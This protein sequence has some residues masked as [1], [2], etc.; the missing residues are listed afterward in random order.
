MKKQ[1]IG[2]AV[3]AGLGALFMLGCGSAS[4]V[5]PPARSNATGSLVVFGSDAPLCDVL[6]FQVTIIGATLTSQGGGDPVSILSSGQSIPVD[7]ARLIDFTALLSF[8]SVPAGTYSQLTLTLSSPQ[9][10]VLDVQQVPPA[11]VAI[12]ATL[13]TSTATADIDPP[14]TVPSNGTA[15][16]AIDFRLRKSVQT[17]ANGQ[18]TGTVA[19]VLRAAPSIESPENGIGEVD[20]LHGIVR[21][22]STTSS[23]PSFTG[24]FTLQTRGGIGAVFTIYATG[25][26]YFDGVAGLSGLTT[27]TFAEVEAFVDGSGNIVAKEVEVEEQGSAFERRGAF[28]GRVIDVTRDSAGNA[29]QFKLFVREEHPDLSSAVPLRSALTVNISSTTRFRM[30]ARGMNQGNFTFDPTALG[31]G[32][33]VVVHGMLQPGTPPILDAKGVFL[34]PQTILGN[35]TALLASASDGKTGGF[36]LAPCGAIF[37][38]QP[39]TT[40]T[41]GRTAF[42]GVSGLVGLGPKPTLAVK[43]LLIYE[44]TN[45]SLN[46]V[47]WT[48]PTW[49]MEA[50]QIHQLPQ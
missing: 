11:P 10:T 24:S 28:I 30:V 32:Q 36:A 46:S 7:F 41:F 48:A 37:Q 22:V 20:E 4:M 44:Q 18:V 13:T 12:P 1:L 2:L 19:P 5:S 43:G 25:N 8:A 17:D 49:V 26:T 16:L 3:V 35:Y 27:D 50:K 33:A 42:A 40:L 6:S 31:L 45:G 38:G 47:T 15:G 23:N 21:S 14:L 9:L 29:T 39:I 34:R